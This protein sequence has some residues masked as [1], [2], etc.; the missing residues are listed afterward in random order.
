MGFLKR[1]AAIF[2][3]PGSSGD[4]YA[5]YY[6]VRCRRCGEVIRARIDLRNELS[7]EYDESENT[8]GYTYRKVLIGRG[9][10]FQAMEVN[11]T[12]DKGRRVA[13][14]EVTGGEFVTA[15]EYEAAN[16]Q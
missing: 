9:R 10:C 11:M 6:Y 14:R 15:E 7:P 12:F 8:S 1:L 5:L 13:S 16:R 4:D 2:G 3:G